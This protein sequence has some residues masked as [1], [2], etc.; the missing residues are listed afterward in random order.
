[1]FI[2]YFIIVRTSFQYLKGSEN[3]YF[4]VEL[5]FSLLFFTC[6]LTLFFRFSDF[7]ALT[8]FFLSWIT[9]KCKNANMQDTAN[10]KSINQNDFTFLLLGDSSR[11][12]ALVAN[13]A[14]FF[15]DSEVSDALSESAS[16]SDWLRQLSKITGTSWG[17]DKSD[18][19]PV[20]VLYTSSV[21]SPAFTW[22]ISLSKYLTW[23]IDKMII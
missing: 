2:T 22:L 14:S 3:F 9:T 11:G 10:K 20:T 4:L 19:I 15:S 16:V 23:I 1:M 7:S 6:F 12:R 8:A 13:L 21:F 17:P 5:T 18:L